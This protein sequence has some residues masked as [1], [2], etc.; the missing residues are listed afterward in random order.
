[1]ELPVDMPGN[2]TL[3]MS[4]PLLHVQLF[5]SFPIYTLKQSKLF[6]T[7]GKSDCFTVMSFRKQ[8]SSDGW[9][10]CGLTA[11]SKAFHS[12]R[13]DGRVVMKVCASWHTVY[14]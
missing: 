13:A 8:T 9:I 1:M 5:C 2:T 14:Y 11:V 6:R 12:Y 4:Y 3:D 10:S 7:I